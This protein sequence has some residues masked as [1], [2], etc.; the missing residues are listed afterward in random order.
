MKQPN[1]KMQTILLEVLGPI[2]LSGTTTQ[3]RLY[4]DNANRCLLI[5]LDNTI[6]QQSAIL[7]RQRDVSA[8][9]IDRHQEEETKELLRDLQ[10]MFRA[11]NVINPFANQLIIPEEVFKPLRT[12]AHYLL[13]I[14]AITFVHQYQREVK[15]DAYG[16]A[17]IETTIEDIELAN[18][19]LRDVLLSKSDE[20]TNACRQ[21]LENLKKNLEKQNKESFFRKDIRDIIRINPDTLRYYLSQLTKY[22]YLKIVGGNK[23][24]SGYEYEISDKE[25]YARLSESIETAL[26]TCLQA[27]KNKI[28]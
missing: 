23:H 3:E 28:K 24:K 21:F 22:G 5:Y 17:Y 9:L 26:D 6:Q 1:G 8:G 2:C 10:S 20:L 18:N 11:I 14:E 7:Q 13:F 27:I 4:E 15:K 25:E 12:N 19:L 16:I